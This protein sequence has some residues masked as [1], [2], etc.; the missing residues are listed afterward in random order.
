MQ[1]VGPRAYRAWRR[2]SVETRAMGDADA[3]GQVSEPDA[4]LLGDAN[5]DMGMVAEESP[6]GRCCH[7][8]DASPPRTLD[9][10]TKDR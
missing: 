8:F 3:F 9:G 7:Q 2:A 10:P 4:R 1:P 6:T 5:Q